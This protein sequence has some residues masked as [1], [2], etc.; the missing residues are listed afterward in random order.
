VPLYSP[1]ALLDKRVWLAAE[2]LAQALKDLPRD[3]PARIAIALAHLH[4]EAAAVG[5]MT[6]EEVGEDDSA[7]GE[8]EE[9]AGDASCG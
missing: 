7:L 3:T 2:I 4:A 1:P 8:D 9:E 5:Q 6:R